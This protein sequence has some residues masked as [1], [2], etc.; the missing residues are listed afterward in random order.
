MVFLPLPIMLLAKDRRSADGRRRDGTRLR[1]RG[2]GVF[3]VR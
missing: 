2:G 3:V 1:S